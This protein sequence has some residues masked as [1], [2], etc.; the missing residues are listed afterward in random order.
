MTM[1][2]LSGSVASRLGYGGIALPARF[3]SD[4]KK[5]IVRRYIRAKGFYSYDAADETDDPVKRWIGREVKRF[6]AEAH[7]HVP[8]LLCMANAPPDLV[9]TVCNA[10]GIDGV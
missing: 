5:K 1:L 3:L 6:L 7:E 10:V 4:G 8:F 9:D 2:L